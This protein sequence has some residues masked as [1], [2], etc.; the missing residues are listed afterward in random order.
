MNKNM[1]LADRI[2]RIVIA[3]IIAVLYAKGVISGIL[4]IILLVFAGVIV[5]TS[6]IK[7]CPLYV[8]F[9]ISTL[10]SKKQSK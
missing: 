2:I 6:L 1:G 9:R 10:R 3:A 8:P 4:G 5:L 7:V